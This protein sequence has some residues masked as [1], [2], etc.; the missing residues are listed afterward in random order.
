M[1]FN[2][3]VREPSSTSPRIRIQA[4]GKRVQGRKPWKKVRRSLE[5]RNR[6]NRLPPFLTL[7]CG[8][9]LMRFYVRLWCPTS[10]A[11]LSSSPFTTTYHTKVL[12]SSTGFAPFCFPVFPIIQNKKANL[13]G[14]EAPLRLVT[15]FF[16]FC[17]HSLFSLVSW[18]SFCGRTKP[19]WNLWWKFKTVDNKLKNDT[20]RRSFMV[21]LR[22]SGKVVLKFCQKFERESCR[23]FSQRWKTLRETSERKWSRGG[24]WVLWL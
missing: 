10:R 16:S 7:Y 19:R 23:K 17:I 12:K 5:G 2:Q 24:R 13:W 1:Q 11:A 15:Y 18:L 21:S 4:G 22:K 8:L 20:W 14:N 6:V 9:C 3:A